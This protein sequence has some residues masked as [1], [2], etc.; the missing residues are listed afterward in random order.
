VRLRYEEKLRIASLK[1][2]YC[3]DCA[4]KLIQEIRDALRRERDRDQKVLAFN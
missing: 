2:T 4:R 3:P 1:N